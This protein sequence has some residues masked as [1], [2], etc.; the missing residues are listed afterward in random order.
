MIYLTDPIV[1]MDDN[2]IQL[3]NTLAICSKPTSVLEIGVGSGLVTK[4]LLDALQ[5][6]QK[7]S[8][9]TC[10][11]NFLDWNGQTPQGF[12]SFKDNIN[13]INSNE[14][15]FII[16][17]KETYDFIVSDADHHHTNEWVDKTF[18][19]L[20]KGGI[21]IYHDVT[22]PDFRNLYDIVRYAELHQINHVVLNK[23][24][25]PHER[26]ERGLMIIFKN[27]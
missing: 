20:N 15:D 10:V 1:A 27:K 3:I 18:N 24:S 22:N 13:F 2:H 12:D 21:L 17:C 4:T 8:T 6:N 19:L 14:R 11:D 16:S 25:L 7:N 23:S 9:L 26:C 5:Y